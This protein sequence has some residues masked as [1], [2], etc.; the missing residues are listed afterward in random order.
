VAYLE[1][2][3]AIKVINLETKKTRLILDAKYNYSYSDGDQW[4]EW[5]PDGKWFIAN[6]S[7]HSVFL[8][9]VA[10]IDAKGGSEPINLTNSGYSDNTPRWMMKG[11]V[12]LWFS[13]REG[14]RSH[15]SWGSQDDVYAMFLNQESWDKFNLSK[16]EYE[17][18][19]EKEKK[20]KE[21]EK[22]KE[23]QKGLFDENEKEETVDDIS[24]DLD[25]LEDRK[26]KLTI[27]SS[28]LADAILTPDGEN[29]YY[30]SKFEDGYDLWVHK[31]KE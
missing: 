25:K 12:I 17:L 24:I 23:E 15:G 21:K 18:I 14:M 28:S 13:D 3:E 29:L 4:Y 31:L 9:D 26:V 11:N 20:E 27:N 10:L 2:R 7:P 8:N 5:S 6:Y 19:K 1:E 30:L 22:K 16:E